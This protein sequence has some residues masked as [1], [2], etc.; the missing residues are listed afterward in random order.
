M[1]VLHCNTFLVQL[2]AE[3]P[4]GKLKNLGIYSNPMITYRMIDNPCF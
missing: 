4:M 1:S 3:Y 2:Y